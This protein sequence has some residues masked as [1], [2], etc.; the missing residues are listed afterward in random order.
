MIKGMND[1]T[2]TVVRG[3]SFTSVMRIRFQKKLIHFRITKKIKKLWRV[4]EKPANL[5]NVYISK[6][7]KVHIFHSLQIVI[8]FGIFIFP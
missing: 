1:P 7:N 4:L 2:L 5:I 8:N 3:N 6:R